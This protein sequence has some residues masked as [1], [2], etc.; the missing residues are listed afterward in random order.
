MNAFD[1]YADGSV[2]NPCVML[3]EE[4][5]AL[6]LSVLQAMER[7][8][9]SAS[10]ARTDA[11][12]LS[13]KASLRP[14][15]VLMDLTLSDTSGMALLAQL[16]EARDCGIIVICSLDDEADRI[17]GLELGADDYMAKPPGLRELVARIRAVHRRVS[18]RT[19]ATAT[20]QA[21]PVLHV[22][23]IRINVGHR[24]VHTI[25]GR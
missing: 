5:E 3:I 20:P 17:V 8:G 16:A 1:V 12:V 4:D 6:A 22:G 7:A 19:R 9:F 15:V 13:L 21:A 10:W 25:E 18:T 14:H 2:S 24:T 23:P 11:E